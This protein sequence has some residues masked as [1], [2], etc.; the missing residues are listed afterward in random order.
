MAAA[1]PPPPNG[2]DFSP[3]KSGC[4]SSGGS[5]PTLRRAKTLANPEWTRANAREPLQEITNQVLAGTYRLQVSLMTS[6]SSQE[7]RE[8]DR[9]ARQTR[10]DDVRVLAA[11]TQLSDGL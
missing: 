5:R 8:R 10:R 1:G 4:N 3:F 9:K 11:V 2:D 7:S 6:C